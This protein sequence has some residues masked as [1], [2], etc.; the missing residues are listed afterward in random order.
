M[1]QYLSEDS[2][3]ALL[4]YSISEQVEAFSTLRE[5]SLPYPVVQAHQ[6]HDD[7]V[8]VLSSFVPREELEG[9]DA[10]VTNTPGLAIG[11]RTA[12]CIPVLLFDS[13]N[14]VIAAVH[15]GWK[16]T[17]KRISLRAIETMTE[18]FGTKSSDLL[19][20]IGPGIG[21][22]SF[23]IGADVA[24]EFRAAGFPISEIL[25][26][27]G[28]KIPG[29]MIGGLHIDLWKA[30][31]LILEQAGVLRANIF[32]SE[33]DTYENTEFFSA[34]REGVSCGRIINAIML[35]QQ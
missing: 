14:K 12:D 10:L 1:K 29:T 18:H 19:A 9:I 17:V 34:R 35:K 21:P 8:A 28:D 7:K 3:A 15:A 11:V 22:R 32:V 30:N 20:V 2:N 6:T 24:E 33:I 25:T 23:Q 31:Q 13:A 4:K 5:A 26:H 27:N 16:G